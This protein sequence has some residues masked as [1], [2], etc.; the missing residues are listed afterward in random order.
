[1]FSKFAKM[2]LMTISI[3]VV[4][5]TYADVGGNIYITTIS[6]PVTGA[7]INR[8]VIQFC[9]DGTMSIADSRQDGNGPNGFAF[10]PFG[11]QQGNWESEHDSSRDK[12]TVKIKTVSFSFPKY[13][14]TDWPTGFPGQQSITVLT[15]K[16]K[17]KGHQKYH[18]KVY[19]T[20]FP[21]TADINDPSQGS[22]PTLVATMVLD[23]VKKP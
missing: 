8:S 4:S 22:G 21:I 9:K 14:T 6:D 20:F 23:L 16:L 7:F 5:A 11:L 2:L 1:M 12:Q 18:G 17:K 15:S 3:L 10:A 19:L 13:L